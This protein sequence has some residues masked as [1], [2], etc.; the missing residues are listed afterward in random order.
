ML[1]ILFK[2]NATF[3]KDLLNKTNI[4]TLSLVQ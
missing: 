3:E 1:L 2:L 4:L